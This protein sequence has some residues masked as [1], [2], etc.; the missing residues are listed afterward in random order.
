VEFVQ[1]LQHFDL[2]R[3][4]AL[5][6]LITSQFIHGGWLHISGNMVFLWVFG[7]NVEDTV[8][9]IRYIFFYLI[10]GVLA[11]LTHVAFNL[12]SDVP[13]VGASGAIAGI[14]GAYLVLYPTA[15]VRALVPIFLFLW[16]V[17]LP[18]VLLIGIWFLM[19]LFSGLTAIGNTTG[20]EAGVAFWAHIG[21]FIAGLVLIFFFRQPG[22]TI[23]PARRRYAPFE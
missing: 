3:I 21:G 8:G 9:H 5:Y 22:R 10:C 23:T 17:H 15:T 12:F 1:S 2:S 6:P 20:G 16:P 18:A 4:D 14:M 19:Q 7:D 11:A 13:S